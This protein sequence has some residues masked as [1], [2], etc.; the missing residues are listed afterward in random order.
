MSFRH[1]EKPNGIRIEALLILLINLTNQLT[2]T[3]VYHWQK[4]Q[5]K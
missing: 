4:G 2:P 1:H 5:T 3:G